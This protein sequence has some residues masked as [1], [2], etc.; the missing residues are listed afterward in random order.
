ME[1]SD[2]LE[3]LRRNFVRRRILSAVV[4]G[5]SGARSLRLDKAEPADSWPSSSDL[6]WLASASSVSLLLTDSVLCNGEKKKN[7]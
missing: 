6:A 1:S 7:Q 2:P 3:C 5:E 4:L